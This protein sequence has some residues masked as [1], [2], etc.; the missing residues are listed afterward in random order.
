MDE[1]TKVDTGENME[2]I[3]A[4]GEA[5]VAESPVIETPAVADQLFG[6][7]PVMP[8]ETGGE[9]SFGENGSALPVEEEKPGWWTGNDLRS[10]FMAASDDYRAAKVVLLGAPMDYTASFRPGS[11]FG[12]KAVREVSEAL[13]EYSYY[14]EKDL[15]EIPFFD[16]GDLYLPFGNVPKSLEM[17]GGSV[18]SIYGD[19]KIPFLLGGEHLISWPAIE[20]LADKYPKLRVVHLDAHTD[21][22]ASYLGEELSHSSVMRLVAEKLGRGRVYQFGI[23]S[24]DR[25]DF[26]YAKEKT[27][28]FPEELLIP[29]GACKNLITHPIYLTIDIDVLDPAYAPGTGTPESGGIRPRELF[30]FI[31]EMAKLE[32]VGV[33]LVEIAPTYDPSGAT[34]LLGAKLVR[35]IVMSLIK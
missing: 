9:M 21:L 31:K 2:P 16:A 4:T 18:A 8:T 22:R 11:R 24:G 3:T 5:A 6:S 14:Q 33:D 20:F 32:I 34:S 26:E 27:K 29:F 13:E 35:E 1:E 10:K 19:G 7:E 12:P 17:I 28:L 15:R 23:R 25:A 30:S